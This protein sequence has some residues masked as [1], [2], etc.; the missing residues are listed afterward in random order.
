MKKKIIGLSIICLLLTACGQQGTNEASVDGESVP[1]ATEHREINWKTQQ[2]VY[3]A[4][5]VSAYPLYPGEQITGMDV[6]EATYYNGYSQNYC[7]W[8]NTIFALYGFYADGMEDKYYICCYDGDTGEIR[9]LPLDLSG[10]EGYG[11]QELRIANLDM[12]G[13]QELVAFVQG[14]QGEPSCTVSFRAVHMT[15]EGKVLSAT[16]L[17]PVLSELG[18]DPGV[19]FGEIYVDNEGYYYVIPPVE[20]PLQESQV[21]ILDSSGEAVGTMEPGEGY[22]WAKWAMKLPD[23]SPA[24]TWE[25]YEQQSVQ[26]VSYDMAEKRSHILLEQKGL[27]D[28]WLWT[29]M[30]DGYLYFVNSADELMRCDISSGS[31]EDCMYF[32]MLGMGT[33]KDSV[34]MIMGTK[35]LPEILG[36]KNLETVICR[37]SLES[38]GVD[39]I[40]LVSLSPNCEYLKLHAAEFSRGNEKH[41]IYVQHPAE[42]NDSAYRDR[43]MAELTS[44]KGA[45]MYFVSAEDMQ[46]LAANGVL[47]DLT[48]LLSPE[49]LSEIYPGVLEMSTIDGELAGI[50]MELAYPFVVYVSKE[51]WPE[52]SWTLEE[53]LGVMEAHPELQYP[54]MATFAVD[55]SSVFEFLVMKDLGN[56]PFLDLEKGTCDFDNSLFVRALELAGTYKGKITYEEV[57]EIY[58]EKNW[59]ALETVVPFVAGYDDLEIVLGEDYH[60]VGYPTERGN[61]NFWDGYQFLVVNQDTP[62]REEIA[63]YLE[64]LLSHENQS[65][66]YCPIRREDLVA[67]IGEIEV[68]DEVIGDE[69]IF[70]KTTGIEYKSGIYI[71]ILPDEDGSYWVEGYEALLESCAGRSEDTSAIKEII[72]EE[73]ESYFSGSKDAATVADII[74]NRVQL[75]LNE[76]Q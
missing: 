4:G 34:R 57:Q 76:R 5:R 17:Y 40:Q 23:G 52:D 25:N 73:V 58:P 70:R 20:N 68:I 74:Q 35:G 8:E 2:W 18:M 7:T 43:I 39:P 12:Q 67:R 60:A 49:T 51:L 13:E 9:Q 15:P 19:F 11:E 48:E 53:A 14:W 55:G 42:Y 65:E 69:I 41:P 30:E 24:F 54:I 21:V 3:D 28:A 56:S 31:V 64:V 1:S 44:G 29:L 38:N 37:L 45:D 47:A 59:V 16:D 27:I 22:C 6:T 75:Y 32:P 71:E 46:I 36:V 33:A 62:Y 63:A 61:G 10:L 26:L 50:V 66:I 72:W